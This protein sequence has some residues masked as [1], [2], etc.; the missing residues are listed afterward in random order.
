M[1]SEEEFSTCESTAST[2]TPVTNSTSCVSSELTAMFSFDT[3]LLWKTKYLTVVQRRNERTGEETI[4]LSFSKNFSKTIS[5]SMVCAF[6][7]IAVFCECVEDWKCVV[8][9]ISSPLKT[10]RIPSNVYL[11]FPQRNFT[12]SVVTEDVYFEISGRQL[13]Q[14]VS[15]YSEVLLPGH[16]ASSVY[17]SV[18]QANTKRIAKHVALGKT[19]KLKRSKSMS[20]LAQFE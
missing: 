14:T 11:I 15:I 18:Y 5:N 17:S 10:P 4:S 1:G 20:F 2:L 3:I 8:E 16:P 19:N 9:T 13:D 12:S 7:S 6:N